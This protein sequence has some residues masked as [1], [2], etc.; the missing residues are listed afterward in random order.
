MSKTPSTDTWRL[1]INEYAFVLALLAIPAIFLYVAS[2][3]SVKVMYL[4]PSFSLWAYA[5]LFR[6]Y[7]AP[8]NSQRPIAFTP[9]L[10][11]CSYLAMVAISTF[12]NHDTIVPS[13]VIRDAIIISSPFLFFLSSEKT[14]EKYVKF[15]FC[16]LAIAFFLFNNNFQHVFSYLSTFSIRYLFFPQRT[17]IEFDLG[18]IFGLFLLY[19]V[20]RRQLKW[21]IL[22]LVLILLSGK[23]VVLLAAIPALLLHATIL[24]RGGSLHRIFSCIF[25]AV[26]LSASAV[27]LFELVDWCIK[28]FDLQFSAHFFLMGRSQVILILREQIFDN[29]SIL[30]FFFGHGPGMADY[31]LGS[32]FL[33]S[34]SN[35]FTANPHNDFLKLFY[36]YGLLGKAAFLVGASFMFCRT[37]HG[38][39]VWTYTLFVFL[40]DNPL[41]FFVYLFN[42]AL[43]SNTEE[44]DNDK[45]SNT[46]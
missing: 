11:S 44:P 17:L 24:V 36:D 41:I 8:S 12:L 22:C 7:G 35:G 40:V 29:S 3:Q 9:L 2:S 1:H 6:N 19:F 27:F 21:I 20:Q 46:N 43:V 10:Q 5:I 42:L 30:Q 14:S 25:I 16:S 28:I 37:S 33:V 38:A 32:N 34:W 18:A 15:S 26:A 31:F 45:P 4:L 13:L 23:R 39:L